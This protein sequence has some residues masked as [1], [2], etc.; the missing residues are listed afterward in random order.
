ML[1]L[2]IETA[3]FHKNEDDTY[4]VFQPIDDKKFILFYNV[5]VD[6][7]TE[8]VEPEDGSD[9]FEIFDTGKTATS[10]IIKANLY[11]FKEDAKRL[12]NKIKSAFC[13]GGTHK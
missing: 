5:K 3:V 1:K 4:R 13:S 6:L 8:L 2:N 12:F 7:H 11:I 10:E 9:G